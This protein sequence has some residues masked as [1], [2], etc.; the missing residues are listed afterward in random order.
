MRRRCDEAEAGLA[1]QRQKSEAEIAAARDALAAQG[2]LEQDKQEQADAALAE[3][4]ARCNEAEAKL[5]RQRETLETEILAARK[6]A[7]A[8]D[9]TDADRERDAGRALAELQARCE[10]AEASLRAAQTARESADVDDTY[11]RGLNQEIKTLQ[12]ILVDRETAIARAEASL[13]QMQ[14]GTVARP[15]PA[16]WEPLPG[17][18]RHASKE[19][20]KP[21]SHLVRDFILVFGVVMLACVAYFLSPS[22]LSAN[23]WQLPNLSNLFVA[24]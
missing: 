5:D 16:H 22:L 24:Q 15:A 4:T 20:K 2:A 17:S 6:D 7:E 12:A 23:N 10:A 18:L 1:R 3:L 11:V 8:Q 9:A 13:E 19:D 21:D 14:V